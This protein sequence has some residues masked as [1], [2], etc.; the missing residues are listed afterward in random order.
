MRQISLNDLYL[1]FVLATRMQKM[2]RNKLIN[3]GFSWMGR[4]YLIGTFAEF[5]DNARAA[6]YSIT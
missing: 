2:A 5:Y 1:Q 3:R 4:G 6:G